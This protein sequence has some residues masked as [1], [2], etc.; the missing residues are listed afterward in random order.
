MRV[1]LSLLELA[2]IAAG[3]TPSDA[4]RDTLVL[5]RRAEELGLTRLWVAEHHNMPGIGSS[6]PAVLLAALGAAT[7]RIRIGSGGVMLP[8]HAPLVVAEQFGTLEA[9]YPGRIDLGLGRAPGTDLSTARA[10]R[11]TAES[12]A[13]EDF[14]R[15]IAELLA[16]FAGSFPPGH[17]YERIAAVPSDGVVPPIWMLGSST[18][19]AKMAGVNGL[20]YAFAHHFSAEH[21]LPA[22]AL[23]RETFRPSPE[24]DRPYVALAVNVVA[25]PDDETARRWALPAALSFV[26]LR[27]GRPGRIPTIAEAEAYPWSE[28]ERAF[29]ASRA[30]QQAVG[31]P[32]TV[33]RR[34]EE[35]LAATRADELIASA[36]LPD[37]A[38]R[39][40]SLERLRGLLDDP[41]PLGLSLRA[42]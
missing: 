12:L 18:W 35:L 40:E 28:G 16:F 15:Q 42:G 24:L 38:L 17:P 7:S 10:L 3:S 5:A 37:L 23:Y 21:T 36:I 31:G 2:P 33:R 25:G 26:H 34:L 30:A 29:V 19:S 27:K 11:R 6:A 41:L 8:N 4:L 14:P 20:P 13:D 32:E 1:P 39:L 22:L 9:L